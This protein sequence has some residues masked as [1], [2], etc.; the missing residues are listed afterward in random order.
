MEKE[1]NDWAEE[2]ERDWRNS[3]AYQNIAGKG[4]NQHA[5]DLFSLYIQYKSQEKIAKLTRLLV[6]RT[7]VLAIGTILVAILR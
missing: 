1:F 6:I 2:F 5:K 7:W 4:Y 3:N